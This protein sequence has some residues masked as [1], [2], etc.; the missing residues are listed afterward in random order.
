[1]YD[2]GEFQVPRLGAL[3]C[4]NGVGCAGDGVWGEADVRQQATLVFASGRASVSAVFKPAVEILPSVPA[5]T[6]TAA[7]PASTAVPELTLTISDLKGNIMPT[8]SQINLTTVDNSP[9]DPVRTRGFLGAS[10]SLSGPTSYVVPN[11][12]NRLVLNV[13]LTTCTTRDAV[14]VVITTPLGL[15]TPF[16]FIVP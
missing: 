11:T 16:S 12:L 9:N 3:S 15:V 1:M 13:A 7:L 8:G 2:S 5:T 10:C 6:S 14:N 4:V